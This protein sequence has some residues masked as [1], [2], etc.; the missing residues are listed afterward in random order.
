MSRPQ[1]VAQAGFYPTPPRVAVAIARHLAAAAATGRGNRVLRLLDPCAGTGDA[2]A[3]IARAIGAESYGIELNEERAEAARGRLD[4]LLATSAF[5][6]RLANGGFSALFLN[7][8]YDR[9][10]RNAA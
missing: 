9:A 5:S 3:E 8:P 6:V 2:A 1:A 4:H 10:P 7:P